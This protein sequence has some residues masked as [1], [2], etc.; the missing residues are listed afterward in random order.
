MR[1]TP[2]ILGLR[3][4]APILLGAAAIADETTSPSAVILLQKCII[5]Y[6][7]AT[8]VGSNYNVGLIQEC[9][10]RPG[11]RVKAGQVLG[12]LFNKDVLAEMEL[13]ATA[14]E[15]SEI[16]IHQNEATLEVAR[17]K[18]RRAEALISRNA[19]S[20]QDFQIQ[21]L[22]V[23]NADL[24][25]KA[26]IMGRRT[27]ES[28][29]QLSKALVAAREITSPHDGVVVEIYKNTGE[30]LTAGGPIIFKVV[31]VDRMRVTGY[32]DASDAWHVR[33]K[34][35]VR[36]MPE[37]E[38]VDL[39]IEREV[40]EGK[41]TFVDSEIDPKTR[42]CRVFAEVENRGDLLRSGLDCRMEI[43]LRNPSGTRAE[44]T[45]SVLGRR[46]PADTEAQA[47]VSAADL[48]RGPG[49][50]GP[51]AMRLMTE[52]RCH[53]SLCCFFQRLD[54]TSRSQGNT[55]VL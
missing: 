47:S 10:V 25:L 52:R 17:A 15:S 35:T 9:L 48:L 7:R 11:D 33:P 13:R 22:E 26:A 23:K 19:L 50:G 3:L 21:Q 36:V 5:E 29:L 14:L 24:E 16:A 44:A 38:G 6:E 42:T 30:S 28:Q 41:I 39:P 18:L 51:G 31:K 40:F 4:L 49:T 54:S 27:A 45:G 46:R 53:S 2:V 12:R 34:Q 43:D 1:R 32:L 8:P 20:M 55:S 37:L